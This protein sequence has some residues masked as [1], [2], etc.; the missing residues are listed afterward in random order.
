[1][2]RRVPLSLTVPVTGA[3][4]DKSPL[5]RRL[6]VQA[7]KRGENVTEWPPPAVSAMF[8]ERNDSGSAGG[9]PA[10]G[11]GDVGGNGVTGAGAG[12]GVKRGGEEC[13]RDDDAGL[14]VH[15]AWCP[16]GAEIYDW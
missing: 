13:A 11:I 12:T 2:V 16:G 6:Y 9:A 15:G 7:S 14:L 8:M 3:Q 1:M 4:R 10:R 5:P